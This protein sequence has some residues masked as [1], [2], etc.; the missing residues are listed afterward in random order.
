MLSQK[1]IDVLGWVGESPTIV[2]VKLRVG[3]GTL[4]Q[5][6]GYR[7][8]FV[9]EFRHIERPELL[10]VC[11]EIARDDRFV[12]GENKIPVVVV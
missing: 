1:R 8:L 10:I 5:V 7:A 12:L 2:E 9:E 4:G 3:L 11:E 6:L